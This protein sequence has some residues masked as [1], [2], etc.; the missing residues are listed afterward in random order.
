MKSGWNYRVIRH[1]TRV[2]KKSRWMY[3]FA[4]HETYYDSNG[5]IRAWSEK[6]DYPQGDSLDEL[7]DGFTL[8]MQAFQKPVLDEWKLPEK[9]AKGFGENES[10]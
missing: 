5:L 6:P 10:N 1:R 8:Y 2:N 3:W 9:G 4:V 7:R